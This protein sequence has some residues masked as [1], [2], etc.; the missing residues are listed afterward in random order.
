MQVHHTIQGEKGLTQRFAVLREIWEGF[1]EEA[2][3]EL[4]TEISK[5]PFQENK[6]VGDEG[7]LGV[8]LV[9]STIS[10]TRGG[11]KGGTL[12]QW[13]AVPDGCHTGCTGVGK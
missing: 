12:R 1:P 13:Q 4:R 6:S 10:T 11:A 2:A 8:A 3:S 9:Q 5:V 7:R